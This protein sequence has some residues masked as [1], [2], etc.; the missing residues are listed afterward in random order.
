[1]FSMFYL[2]SGLAGA[3]LFAGM[4]GGETPLIGASGAVSGVLGAFLVCSMKIRIK[5]FYWVIWPGTFSAPAWIMLPLWFASELVSA[6][7]APAGDPVAYWA[8]VGGFGFGAIAALAIRRL[9]VEGMVSS[10]LGELD[11]DSGS[12]LLDTTRL[13]IRDG[14][15][16]E[17]IAGANDALADGEADPAAVRAYLEAVHAAGREHDVVPTLI[18]HAA[19]GGAPRAAERARVRGR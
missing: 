11:A 18:E 14:R 1:M 17:A 6:L 13:A 16:D 15:M 4:D 9:G 2:A 3:A 12:P 10:G 19:A 7:S 5:F 8:H